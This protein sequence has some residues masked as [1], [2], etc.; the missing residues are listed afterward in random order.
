MTE[1]AA[2]AGAPLE[3]RL[4]H[5]LL[6]L[7]FLVSGTSLFCLSSRQVAEEAEAAGAPLKIQL[8]HQLANNHCLVLQKLNRKREVRSKV[9]HLIQNPEI[10]G[11][12]LPMRQLADDHCLALQALN[13]NRE[14]RSRVCQSKART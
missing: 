14:V 11:T 8:A 2:G 6:R 13:H 9:R 10:S 12:F 5:Q 7:R 4:A 1:E 3:I